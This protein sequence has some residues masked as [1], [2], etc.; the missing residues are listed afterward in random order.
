MAVMLACGPTWGAEADE[1]VHLTGG[2]VGW[3]WYKNDGAGQRWDITPRG[4]VDDGEDNAY[5]TGM[6]LSVNGKDFS[7]NASGRLSDDGREVEIGPWTTSGVRV[8]RRIRVDDREGYCRWID[9]FENDAAGPARALTVEYTTRQSTSITQVRT[10][11]GADKPLPGDWALVTGN[12]SSRTPSVVHILSGPNAEVLP[13]IEIDKDKHQVTYRYTLELRPGQRRALCIYQATRASHGKAVEYMTQ[14]KPGYQLARAHQNLRSL[15]ANISGSMLTLGSLKLPRHAKFD[16]VILTNG[17]ELVG[18]ITNSSLSMVTAFGPLN[19]P[20]ERTLGLVVPSADEPLVHV[21]LVDGQIVAGRLDEPVL[22][23]QLRGSDDALDLEIPRVRSAGFR[24]SDQ[25]PESVTISAPTAVFRTGEQLFFHPDDLAVDFQSQYGR[26]RIDPSRLRGAHFNG[27]AGGL[28]R[29]AFVNGSMLSG[30]LQTDKLTLRLQLG[31]EMSVGRYLLAKAVFPT[32]TPA[33][34]PAAR[35]RLRNGDLLLGQLL[36][37]QFTIDTG[38]GRVTVARG[39]IRLAEFSDQ[40][41]GEARIRLASGSSITG[42]LTQQQLRVRVHPGLDLPLYTGHIEIIQNVV[43]DDSS[44]SA[45]PTEEGSS[46]PSSAPVPAT[47]DR[48]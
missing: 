6:A 39:D 21:A 1:G 25:R 45:E 5:N 34:G 2:S 16:R 11:S 28:H 12:A 22:H 29:L 43:K 31:A 13:R 47:P 27:G 24:V 3:Y 33:A 30:L 41:L 15:V 44:P 23:L 8:Y 32:N 46:S 17:D 26:F 10:S 48:F 7:W 40:R 4:T 18:T 19:L 14:F 42:R 20:A 38:S 35:V 37:E 36:D 9:L